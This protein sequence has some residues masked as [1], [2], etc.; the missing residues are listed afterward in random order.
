MKILIIEDSP[1]IIEALTICFELRWSEA[2]VI[3]AERG[4][5]GITLTKTESP[6]VVILDIGLPDI[7]GY[8]VLKEIRAFSNVPISILSVRSSE[9]DKVR[10]LEL[11]ADD[12]ITK[13]FNHLELIARI[14]TLLRRSQYLVN[15]TRETSFRTSRLVI[16]FKTRTIKVNNQ[17]V[18]L[19][20]IEYNLL[21]YLVLNANTVLTHRALLEKVWGE[22]YIDS[23]EYL[24]VYIQR[25]RNK[26][27]EEPANPQLFINERGTG[28]KFIGTNLA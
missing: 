19:T 13:P 7:D 6:D 21:Y 1:D 20:P 11:G 27:E 8:E 24:K 26:L 23:P 9:L 12:Y 25:L 10:G 22:E 4:R 2:K 5:D 28:Y 14:Q 15:M 3:S 16:D 18:R 17:P